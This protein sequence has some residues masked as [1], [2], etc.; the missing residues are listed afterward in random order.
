MSIPRAFRVDEADWAIS[1]NAQAL[2]LRAVDAGADVD[3]FE[4][5]KPLF[6]EMP[7]SIL[8]LPGCAVASDTEKDVAGVAAKFQVLRNPFESRVRH[9]LQTIA[10]PVRR[11]EPVFRGSMVRFDLEL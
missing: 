11:Q 5:G 4:F 6:Q 3:E 7:G 1:A 10:A 8:L 2:D 9:P